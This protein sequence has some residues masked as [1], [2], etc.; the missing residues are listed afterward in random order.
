MRTKA[1]LW[2]SSEIEKRILHFEDG[3]LVFEKPYDWPT[4]GHTLEDDDCVQYHLIEYLRNKG[5]IQPT[6]KHPKGMVWTVH[7]LD[8]DTS[9]LCVFVTEK[10]LV[11]RT[12]DAI[13][14]PSSKKVYLA[15][16][17]GHTEWHEHT[18]TSP[19]GKTS[20]NNRGV[21]ALEDGGQTAHS[22]FKVLEQNEDFS[23]LQIRIKTGRTH[24]IRI[25]LQHLGH[26]LLGEL[27]YRHEPC[28]LHFRQALHAH[29]MKFSISERDYEFH[30]ELAE[31]LMALK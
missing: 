6:A 3:L 7:Q 9:G 31:D 11:K 1:P 4:S 27:W 10:R 14:H 18:E 20:E 28:P 29:Y 25:H 8:A 30:S 13:T 19:I 17:N 12:H 22:E 26:P 24:Q 5:T 16:V 2:D 23:L 15:L 21:L